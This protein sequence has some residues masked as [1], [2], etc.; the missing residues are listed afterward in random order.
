M[1]FILSFSHFFLKNEFCCGVGTETKLPVVARAR[2]SS[3]KMSP[4]GTQ[5]VG[6]CHDQ[7]NYLP[8]FQKIVRKTSG[9]NSMSGRCVT[10]RLSFMVEG[11]VLFLFFAQHSGA[12]FFVL[13]GTYLPPA[14]T[15][16]AYEHSEKARASKHTNRGTYPSVGL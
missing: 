14:E 9:I 7:R 6:I 5:K 16:I 13:G 2:S 10:A 3:K 15:V 1:V 11:Q 4:R 12:R 8:F